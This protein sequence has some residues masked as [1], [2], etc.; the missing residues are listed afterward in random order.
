[1]VAPSSWQET[2]NN[3]FLHIASEEFVPAHSKGR[4]QTEEDVDNSFLFLSESALTA[5]AQMEVGRYLPITQW[6][7]SMTIVVEMM[8]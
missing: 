8:S 5:E 7:V 4:A 6:P 1:M 2:E 3:L